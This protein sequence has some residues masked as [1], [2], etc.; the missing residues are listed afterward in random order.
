MGTRGPLGYGY[1]WCKPSEAR[2]DAAW[3]DSFLANGN[4]GQFILGLPAIDIV[5]V[6]RRSVTDEFAIA[7]NLGKTNDAPAGGTFGPNEFLAI[8]DMVLAARS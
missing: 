3:A 5:M 7:R 1:L 6:H 2:T 4:F 8:A